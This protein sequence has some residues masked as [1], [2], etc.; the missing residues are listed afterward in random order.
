VISR[1]EVGM[2]SALAPQT[3][4]LGGPSGCGWGR[5]VVRPCDAMVRGIEE[6]VYEIADVLVQQDRMVLVG[7]AFAWGEERQ[8]GFLC[9][10]G[11]MV[12]PCPENQKC[13]SS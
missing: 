1:A 13:S 7:G 12:E 6:R 9:I 3:H 2:G 5:A 11:I 10:R 4:N 8:G